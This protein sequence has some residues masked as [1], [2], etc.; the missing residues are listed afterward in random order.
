MIVEMISVTQ[1]LS[2]FSDLS[3]VRPDVLEAAAERGTAV[4]RAC[5]AYVLGAW[6]PVD[7][8]YAGY[9]ESFKRWYDATITHY[10]SVEQEYASAEYVFCGHPDLVAEI[11]PAIV[12]VDIK[13]PA[14]RGRLWGAQIAAYMHLT[15][16]ARGGTLRLKRDG[17]RA[18]FDEYTGDAR[19]D[20]AAFLSALNAYRN[21][22]G[23]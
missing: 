3:S 15:G 22:K 9:L 17:S 2:P 14:Q 13:T 1:A 4:H 11:G 6:A 10:L 20:F 12:V 18:I 21:F 19:R 7:A 8:E 16:A 5:L 23:E